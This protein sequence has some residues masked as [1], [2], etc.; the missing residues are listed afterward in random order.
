MLTARVDKVFGFHSCVRKWEEDP[1]DE[2]RDAGPDRCRGRSRGAMAINNRPRRSVLM[3]SVA[4]KH[5]PP[6]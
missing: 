2:D 4:N 3:V 5:S 6:S 1:E